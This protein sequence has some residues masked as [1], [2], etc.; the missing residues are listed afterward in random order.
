MIH[1][2]G[3]K[4]L[5]FILDR[6][7]KNGFQ[8]YIAGGA[9]R[10]MILQRIPDDFDILTN[11]SIKETKALFLDQKV[12]TMGRTFPI[13]TVNGIEISSGR[14]IFD[15][16]NFP[17]SDLAKRDFTINSMAYALSLP[18]TRCLL[19]VIRSICCIRRF[20]VAFAL[21]YLPSR[22][23]RL[24]LVFL[25]NSEIHPVGVEHQQ[26]AGYLMLQ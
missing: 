6:F 21:A 23:S 24:L 19:I 14:A 2:K 12:R 13:C 3:N 11:A 22:Q 4:T 9:V 8:A 18:R 15:T 17:E 26:G 25:T 5:W 20:C 1:I 7:K 10:D 16:S